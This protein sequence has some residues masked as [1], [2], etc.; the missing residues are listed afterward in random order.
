MPST[1]VPN[2]T[3]TPVS[4]IAAAVLTRGS[5]SRGTIDLRA[6][7]GAWLFLKIGRGGTTALTNGVDALVR[8]VLN[9]DTAGAGNVHPAGMPALLSSTAAASSTT[10]ATSDSNAGQAALNVA[11]ITGFAAGDIICIQD[12]GAGVTR[13]E[14]H[15][16]SKT[17]TGILTLD[18]NLQFT[19][20]AAGADTVRNKADVFT[21]IWA[22]G[23]SLYEV[24]FDYGDDAAG[25][26]VTV[27]CLAQRVDSETISP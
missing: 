25:E 23:G 15:R 12:S 10:C 14:W 22:P 7:F 19:H 27:Q 13:L 24:I 26:S 8:R 21:P 16:I 11:L 5:V 1:I 18:R 2:V 17:A 9:N 4:V 6:V 20:T 3:D